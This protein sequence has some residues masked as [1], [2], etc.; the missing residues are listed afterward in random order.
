[1]RATSPGTGSV[2]DVCVVTLLRV[3]VDVTVAFAQS[4]VQP[5]AA[6]GLARQ[7]WEGEERRSYVQCGKRTRHFIQTGSSETVV[8]RRDG[9]VMELE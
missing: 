9:A 6:P 7:V 3:V 2:N 8:G 5:L 4:V 1:M